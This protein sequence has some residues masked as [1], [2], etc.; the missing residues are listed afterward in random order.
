MS[1]VTIQ[2][3]MS[4]TIVIGLKDEAEP[5]KTDAVKIG[6]RKRIQNVDSERVTEYTEGL[7][8]NGRIVIIPE[9]A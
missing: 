7:A 2:N 5:Q 1:L 3:K 4:Q 6:P 8:Q 9:S